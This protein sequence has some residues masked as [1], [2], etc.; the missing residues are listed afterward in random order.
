[1]KVVVLILCILCSGCIGFPFENS[2][3]HDQLIAC[4]V[5]QNMIEQQA[6]QRQEIN[7]AVRNFQI[8]AIKAG[9]AYWNVVDYTGKVEFTWIGQRVKK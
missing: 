8:Q 6:K 9:F 2:A 4:Y 3:E 7:D 5:R 1:M